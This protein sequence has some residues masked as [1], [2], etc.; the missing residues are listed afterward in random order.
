MDEEWNLLDRKA[1]VVIQLSLTS[2]VAFNVFEEKTMKDLM[3]V[4]KK[5]YENPS[6]SNKVF[7]LN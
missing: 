4:L 7:L 1:L 5:L 3:D 2:S 6:T